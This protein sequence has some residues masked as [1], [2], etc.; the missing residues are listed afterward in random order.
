[1]TRLSLQSRLP[2][3]SCIV[4]SAAIYIMV[5]KFRNTIWPPPSQLSLHRRAALS[6]NSNGTRSVYSR[7]NPKRSLYCEMSVTRIRKCLALSQLAGGYLIVSYGLSLAPAPTSRPCSTMILPTAHAPLSNM[8]AAR[9]IQT[10]SPLRQSARS[11]VPG[12]QKN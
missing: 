9:A 1:M 8:A 4:D 6:S 11:F 12:Q 5:V 3:T 7:E 10:G 2:V